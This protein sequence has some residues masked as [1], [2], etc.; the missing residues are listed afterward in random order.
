MNKTTYNKITV[1]GS[2]NQYNILKEIYES[3]LVERSYMNLFF[4]IFL[5]KYD[6]SKLSKSSPLW[7]TYDKKYAEYSEVESNIKTAEYYMRIVNV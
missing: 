3:L 4:D 2:L 7:V 6:L 1:A 5:K